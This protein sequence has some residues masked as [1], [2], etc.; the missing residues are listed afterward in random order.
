MSAA[1]CHR[2]GGAKAGALDACA[3][4]G[5]TPAGRDRLVAWLFS[6]AWLD[7]A[8]RA[9]A[10]RRVLAGEQPDPSR[11]Q[12]AAARRAVEGDLRHPAQGAP[13]T[14]GQSAALLA[15]N[16]LLTPLAGLAVWMGKRAE[17]PRA[18]RQALWLTAPVIALG[19]AVWV[20]LLSARLR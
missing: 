8:E 13:L 17:S 10:A 5:F 9:E 4:C 20:A 3:D 6:D 19:A 1:V 12:L 11:A 7:E 2:C 16:L 18:A 14:T 15:A